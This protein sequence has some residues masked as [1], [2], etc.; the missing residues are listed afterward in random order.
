MNEKPN[1]NPSPKSKFFGTKDFISA[2]K[3]LL[4]QPAL[5]RGFDT[6]LL[7]FQRELTRDQNIDAAAG[8][9][10]LAGVNRF[11]HIFKTLASEPTKDLRRDQDNLPSQQQ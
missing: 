10:Q 6:S 1:Y 2:H 9:H 3:V 8:F 11:L 4:E 5:E 7:Q